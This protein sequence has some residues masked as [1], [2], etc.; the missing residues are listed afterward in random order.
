MK[1]KSLKQEW[2]VPSNKIPIIFIGAGGIIKNCHI[3]AY[4]KIGFELMGVYDLNKKNSNELSKEFSIPNVYE[5]LE[6]A[7]GVKGVVFDIAVPPD[8]LL[9]IVNLLPNNTY[10]LLQ[11]PMGSNYLEAKKILEIC[12][13]KNITAALNFQLRFSPM[14]LCLRD[15]IEKKIIG[16]IVDIEFHYSYF[17]PWHLWPFLEKLDRVEIP[18]NSIHYFDLIRSIFGMPKGVFAYSTGHPKYPK[19]KDAK[20]TAILIYQGNLRCALSLNHCYQF[21]PTNQSANV[22]IEG[23]KGVAFLTLGSMLNYP[24]YLKDKL[25]IKTVDHDWEEIPLEGSWMPDAFGGTMSN[26]QRFISGEDKKLETDVS[27]TINT[28]K[29]VD[30]LLK[31]QDSFYKID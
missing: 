30:A 28:M 20:T 4:K 1:N 11:K 5:S 19:L 7:L 8:Q 25:E 9:K 24:N 23:T 26:L 17:L 10:A 15:I 14:M 6:E 18:L 2:P 12:K 21:G 3:P 13:E 16:E 22:K 31:S 29:L 27:D